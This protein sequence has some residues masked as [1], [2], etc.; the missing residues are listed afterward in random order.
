[1]I[2]RDVYDHDHDWDDDHQKGKLHFLGNNFDFCRYQKTLMLPDHYTTKQD[3]EDEE[4]EEED[5]SIFVFVLYLPFLAA[6]AALYLPCLL[7]Y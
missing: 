1:M 5:R 6:L 2:I 7:T 3:T 4:V